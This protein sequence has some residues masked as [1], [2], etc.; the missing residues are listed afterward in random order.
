MRMNL[1]KTLFFFS[2]SSSCFSSRFGS[3]GLLVG[4]YFL[5]VF[6]TVVAPHVE[7]ELKL[8]KTLGKNSFNYSILKNILDL[9]ERDVY[10][11]GSSSPLEK[12][13]RIKKTVSK[14]FASSRHPCR[15][16]YL[17]RSGPFSLSTF[18]DFS[19][20]YVSQHIAP[21]ARHRHGPP[22]PLNPSERIPKSRRPRSLQ[23]PKP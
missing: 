16:Y 13:F 7:L 15:S 20:Q 3:F 11:C 10:L 9:R 17:Y 23:G 2:S 1:K 4:K 5:S 22:P 14:T 6:G 12:Q 19:A 18:V 21:Y 8:K